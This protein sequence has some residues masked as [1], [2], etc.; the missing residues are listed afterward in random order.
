M[1]QVSTVVIT[2]ETKFTGLIFGRSYMKM[3]TEYQLNVLRL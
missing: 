2:S 3:T 1:M